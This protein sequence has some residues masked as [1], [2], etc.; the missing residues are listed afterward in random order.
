MS[1]DF[2]KD[3]NEEQYQAATSNAK[4]LRIIAGAGTGK[5]RTLTY[6][7][8]YLVARGDFNPKEIVAITFTNKAAREMKDRA[9]KILKDSGL[10]SNGF[11]W[12]GT[13]HGFCVRFLRKELPR[14]F[15][16]F[17]NAFT[18]IDRD[19]SEGYFKKAGKAL[20]LYI[21]KNFSKARNAIYSYKTEGKKP[22][23]LPKESYAYLQTGINHR[24]LYAKYQELL[25][26]NNSIDFDDILI[27]TRDILLADERLRKSYQSSYKAFM[28]DE[29]QDTNDLQYVLVKLFMSKEA[30]L[31]VV[32]DPDQT[33]YTWRGANNALIKDKLQLDFPDL[34][35][36][37][38]DL[39]YRSTQAILD[40]ANMLI[41]NNKDRVKK[42]LK[43]I[44]GEKG[45]DVA[46]ITAYDNNEEAKQIGMKAK[47]LIAKGYHYSDMAIIYRANYLSLPFEKFFPRLH[48]PYVL[49]DAVSFYSRVEIKAA[50]AYLR[51][52]INPGD[53]ASFERAI[54][55]P[56]RKIG[57]K[58]LADLYSQANQKEL[59]IFVF[60]LEDLDQAQVTSGV[61][62]ALSAFIKTYK[63]CLEAINKAQ[64][65][66]DFQ[67]AASN[68]FFNSGLTDYIRELDKE[69]AEKDD[70]K[71]EN[72]RENN[73]KAFL[74]EMN[75]FLTEAF[76][77]PDSENEPTLTDFLIS[78]SLIA[79]QDQ[80]VKNDA[81][82][83]MTG[84]T[85]K[86][87]EFPVVF[88]CGLVDGIFPSSHAEEGGDKAMEEE[89]RL[90]YVA[91]TRAKKVLT[92]S[93]F[94]GMHFGM[95]SIPSRFLKEI[96]F[97]ANLIRYGNDEGTGSFLSRRK[98][99]Q[100]YGD[101]Y[102]YSQIDKYAA[103]HGYDN[104]EGGGQGGYFD[105]NYIPK[106]SSSSIVRTNMEDKK[107]NGVEYKPGDKI[108]HAS[109]GVGVVS[110]VNGNKLTVQFGEGIGTKIL[111]AGFKA[112]KKIE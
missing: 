104:D 12:I 57:D 58:T 53:S 6:R 20:G 101:S 50:L 74:E 4:H 75:D 65:P 66:K 44:S 32:G 22:E 68:Y 109:F 97:K 52:L 10:G 61:K 30:E 93:Y 96:G 112:F 33:I 1:I 14:Y 80:N 36:I 67:T 95:P 60:L 54:Q 15:T 35:T 59:P 28:V 47:D 100:Q 76:S 86:G 62:T 106:I 84:H 24:D 85:S 46:L 27:F 70:E 51:L 19:D 82:S 107:A 92:I 72:E 9:E 55:S 13:F 3:L 48:V 37:T 64:T 17:T 38:L 31:C 105:K 45:E 25:A 89:R 91:M 29:F 98:K 41:G 103:E 23:D 108:A 88:V 87:L 18:I 26:Q 11:P 40:K 78:V 81:I 8:A 21:D 7:L 16:G 2:K 110:Q 5:T 99:N 71:N 69:D 56:S 111:M 43:S 79:S 63:E 39:N 94:G 73:L 102:M 77:N 34:M 90:F 42:D 49:F 83:I